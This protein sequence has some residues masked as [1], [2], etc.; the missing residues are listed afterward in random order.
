METHDMVR[1][2]NQIAA[3]FRAY[4]EDEAVTEVANHIASFW[5]PRMRRQLRDYA[6]AGGDGL[7]PMVMAAVPRIRIPADEAA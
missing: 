2:A 6:A 4:P 5:D 7:D 3:F 1:M